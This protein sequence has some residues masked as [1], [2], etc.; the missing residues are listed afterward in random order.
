MQN[1]P[2]ITADDAMF[3]EFQE[4]IC[5][6]VEDSEPQRYFIADTDFLK[7]SEKKSLVRPNI[8]WEKYYDEG[9]VGAKDPVFS[10]VIAREE[11]KEGPVRHK[12]LARVAMSRAKRP[13]I[14]ITST[15]EII[16]EDET[17]KET[18]PEEKAESE[19]PA[20]KAE[21]KTEGKNCGN[22]PFEAFSR[23]FG[24]V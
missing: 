8:D 18:Q 14:S 16:R 22:D 20:K 4:T 12:R 6:F 10:P 23:Q 2:Y 17:K 21:M 7:D 19:T 1:T 24:G 5:A 11:A 3:R 9:T 15:G 13:M